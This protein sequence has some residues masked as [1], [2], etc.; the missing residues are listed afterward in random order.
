MNP[1]NV[2]W[3]LLPLALMFVV[4]FAWAQSPSVTLTAPAHKAAIAACSDILI[5][6]EPAGIDAANIKSVGFLR[7]DVGISTDSKAP[8]EYTWKSAYPG[9]FKLQAKMTDKSSNVY[10]SDP[11]WITVGGAEPGEKIGNGTF[12]CDKPNPWS[13]NLNQGG[14]ATMAIDTTNGYIPDSP[15]TTALVVTVL[16]PGTADWHIQLHQPFPVL[17]GHSYILSFK[18]GADQPKPITFEV[19]G[20]SDPYTI[21]WSQVISIDYTGTYGPYIF[22]CTVDDPGAYFR[23]CLGANN[24]T[25]YVDD[26]SFIDPD[27][28]DVKENLTRDSGLARDFLMSQNYPNPFNSSTTIEYRLPE[29]AQ[30][31]IEVFNMQGQKI[32]TLMNERQSSGTHHTTWNGTDRMS[33]AATSGLYVYRIKAQTAEKTI[34]I[35]KKILLVE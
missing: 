3:T 22:D 35:Q 2:R 19:Q 24:I 10:L 6:A 20:N 16:N 26:V 28:T 4:S 23:F 18:A 31:L 17:A 27:E 25:F 32:K 9:F 14:N 21:H 33:V 30:V 34:S 29:A 7:N 8:Y 11:I 13:L 1:K 15:D 12:G 5:H